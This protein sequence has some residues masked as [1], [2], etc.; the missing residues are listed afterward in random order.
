MQ[1]RI[2]LSLI[3][4]AIAGGAVASGTCWGEETGS[5]MIPARVSSP[6]VS[7][8][9]ASRNGDLT[10][11][12]VRGGKAKLTP[13]NSKVMFV[14]IHTGDKPDPRT[15]GFGEFSGEASFSSDGKT[16]T[17]L[18]IEMQVDSLYTFNN[19]LT[20]HLKSGD[21]FD[22]REYPTAKFVSSKVEIGADGKGTL[23]GKLTLMKGTEEVKIPVTLNQSG[24]GF[25]L[26]GEVT[27]DR[28]KFGMDKMTEKVSKDVV[29]T[30]VLGEKTDPRSVQAK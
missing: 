21:F 5:A 7:S 12:A 14:G 9:S 25:T 23:S 6:A 19:N 16:L 20:Q 15:C 3:C 28:A 10:P 30:F 29:V 11:I 1:K 2:F 13:S 27:I 17:G 26:Q 4:T 8:E 18:S 24:T 22:A